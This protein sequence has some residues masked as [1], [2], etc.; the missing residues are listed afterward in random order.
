MKT[1]GSETSYTQLTLTIFATK[2]RIEEVLAAIDRIPDTKRAFSGD[3]RPNSLFG[4]E[5]YSVIAYRAWS[6]KSATE[7]AKDFWG[8]F[9]NHLGKLDLSG[10]IKLRLGV[11][12]AGRNDSG[13]A[14]FWAE[15]SMLADWAKMDI[16]F[17][18]EFSE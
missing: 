13:G 7:A 4:G 9:S 8:E 12:I 15:P 1:E 6:E 5:N 11:F 10:G 3:A 16:Q 14:E 17:N 18:I 2:D